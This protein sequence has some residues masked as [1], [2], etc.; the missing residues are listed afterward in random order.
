MNMKDTE[1]YQCGH[2][3]GYDAGY[4]EGRLAALD[5]LREHASDMVDIYNDLLT[6]FEGAKLKKRTEELK[7]KLNIEEL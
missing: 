1:E 2:A 3:D 7:K 4:W 6:E 5:Q